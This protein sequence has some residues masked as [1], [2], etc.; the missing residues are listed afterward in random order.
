[1]FSESPRCWNRLP[2]INLGPRHVSLPHPAT[3]CGLIRFS[4]G[5]IST[6]ENCVVQIR[7]VSFARVE[8]YADALVGKIDNHVEH[9]AYSHEHRTQLTQAFVA[10][11]AFGRDLDCLNNRV[12]SALEIEWTAR[13]AFVSLRGICHQ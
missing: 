2:R 6:F 4:R 11:F 7:R 1:M 5:F 12:V 8:F 3:A 10:I 13:L 9:T